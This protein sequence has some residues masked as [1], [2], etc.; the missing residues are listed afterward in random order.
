MRLGKIIK[1]L[2]IVNIKNYKNYN[3][4]SVTHQSSDVEKNGMFICI[5]GGNYN[6]NDYANVAVECGAKC[7][8]TEDDISIPN[9]TIIRVKN[10][11]IAMS[12]I[13]KNFYNK[14]CDNMK[15]IGIV[16]TAGKTTT[17]ILIARI[18][19]NN[20][21]NIGI[22]GTNGI[23]IGNLRMDNKFTTPDPLEL[24][25]IFYQMQMLGVKTVVMEVSAQAIYLHKMHGIKIDIGV[26]TNISKEH[27]DFF[28]TMENYVRCKMDYFDS[29]NMKECVVCVDDFYGMELAYKTKIPCVT[30]AINQP[31]N[32]FALNID[33]RFDGCKFVANILDD[34]IVVESQ[35]VGLMNV[36]NLLAAMTVAKMC[37]MSSL[38]IG[39]A[40]NN[41]GIIDGRF[42]VFRKDDK[43]VLVDFAHT[44]D[45]IEKTLS[46]V[47]DFC[48]GKVLTIFGCVGYSDMQKR[49]DMSAAVDKYSDFII[50]TVDNRGEVLFED[51]CKDMI[52]GITKNK[53][54]KIENREDAIKCGMEMCGDGDVLCILGKGAEN[55]QKINDERLE[56]S[57]IEVVK[58]LLGL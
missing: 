3:I 13:A 6:G 29:N 55:F 26:F 51:I 46:I 15:I 10:A 25:Y 44:P 24:H 22:I 53:Y 36:Y 1:D 19:S 45:S 42:N 50:L 54:L 27:L 40:V 37:G 34:V 16:G 56:Y 49:I 47:K 39:S 41:L 43:C 48:Q 7:I 18:L 38:Q 8:V 28:E 23:F 21:K 12:V 52:E 57:D 17:S 2:E 31:A 33:L 5:N 30:Y 32:S 35:M 11:R 9:A 14:C 4:K 58:R 20:D